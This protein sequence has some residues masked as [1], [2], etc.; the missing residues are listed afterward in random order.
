MR[1]VTTHPGQAPARAD[2]DDMAIRLAGLLLVTGVRVE[3]QMVRRL[4]NFL[5]GQHGPVRRG[6]G[7]SRIGR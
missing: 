3:R 7:I 5:G 4:R 6:T 2:L 1:M